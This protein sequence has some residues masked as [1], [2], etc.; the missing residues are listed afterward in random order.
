MQ[1]DLID[2]VQATYPDAP[3][4][5]ERGGASEEA[6]KAVAPSAKVM[7]EKV[8]ALFDKHSSL[9]FKEIEKMTGWHR[10]SIKPRLS[11]LFRL[12]KL[13]KVQGERRNGCT[14]YARAS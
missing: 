5:K 2:A 4:F 1:L 14:P 13:I 10:D 8:Y 6:A 3:G 7:R 12:G 9:T 11:D